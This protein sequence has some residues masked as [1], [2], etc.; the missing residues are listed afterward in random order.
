M[1]G[2]HDE[3]FVRWAQ[4]KGFD[5]A[6]LSPMM[7]GQATLR[8]YGV[9]ARNPGEI[10]AQWRKVP[11]HHRQWLSTLATALDLQVLGESFWVIH[12]GVPSTEPLQGLS[13]HEVV[14]WLASNRPS[15]LLWSWNDPETMLPVGRT[16]VMGHSPRREPLDTGE[17]LAIDTGCGT[18]EDGRL[19]AVI[20]PERRFV[21]VGC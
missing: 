17:V 13:P 16:V 18:L 4:G 11:L 10:E 20:L 14:P 8:S 7:A 15:T 3:W 21:T 9:D 5:S 1:L 2:N 6:A 12:A 19:T